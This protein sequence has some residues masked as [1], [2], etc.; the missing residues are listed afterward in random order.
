LSLSK[1][2]RIFVRAGN[3]ATWRRSLPGLPV[4]LVL[5]LPSQH[6]L[7]RAQVERPN[8]AFQ[9]TSTPR[10][11]CANWLRYFFAQRPLHLT[12]GCA[13]RDTLKRNYGSHENS[14]IRLTLLST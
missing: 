14:D 1:S 5:L 12:N 9:W 11:L 6:A 2:M 4:G 7:F 3:M 8:H 10:G 13:Y